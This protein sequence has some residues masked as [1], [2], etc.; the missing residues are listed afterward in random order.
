MIDLVYCLRV[1]HFTF[2]VQF[3]RHCVVR[4]KVLHVSLKLDATMAK[5]YEA[6]VFQ[7]FTCEDKPSK[8]MHQLV[9]CE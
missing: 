6:T 9:F 1:P 3:L 2:H 4:R 8:P 5:A 7:S